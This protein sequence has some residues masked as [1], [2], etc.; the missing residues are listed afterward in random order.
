MHSRILY[1]IIRLNFEVI[2]HKFKLHRTKWYIIM[3]KREIAAMKLIYNRWMNFSFVHERNIISI[4]PIVDLYGG[5]ARNLQVIVGKLEESSS[6]CIFY[7]GR[8]NARP[9]YSATA[10]FCIKFWNITFLKNYPIN[11]T[12]S[13]LT[14]KRVLRSLTRRESQRN[15]PLATMRV[16]HACST[17]SNLD[18]YSHKIILY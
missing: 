8:G 10:T 6:S 17:L 5:I 14:Q 18:R 9:Y 1:T 3:I 12:F 15:W 7:L 2:S 11:E 13:R 4:Y 16:A